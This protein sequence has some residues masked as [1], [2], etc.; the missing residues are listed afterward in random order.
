V[1]GDQV[2]VDENT[3]AEP[4]DDRGR[5]RLEEERWLAHGP[6]TSLMLRSAAIYG[7]GRGV[8]VSIREG[9]LPR[10]AGSGIVS[11][12]HVDDL[13][14]II[15]AGIFSDVQ[16]AWPVADEAP[17]SSEQIARWCRR[18]LQLQPVRG[19]EMPFGRRIAGRRVDGRKI[20]EMLKVD[21]LY[22]SWKTGIKDSLAEE[23]TRE[24]AKRFEVK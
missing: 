1:Y 3:P 23:M 13:A 21:L 10:S 8:H 22:P 5:L 2:D 14:A 9:K 6:W 18:L 16:G 7:P 19:R 20:R 11:R 12:I 15:E 24:L 17:C 4:S